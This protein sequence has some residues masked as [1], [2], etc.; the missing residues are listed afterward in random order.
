MMGDGGIS[1]IFAIC[2]RD[3]GLNATTTAPNTLLKLANTLDSLAP[4]NVSRKT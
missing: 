2:S 3:S 4:E 1:S